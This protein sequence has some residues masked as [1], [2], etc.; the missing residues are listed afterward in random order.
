MTFKDYI[1]IGIGGA[2]GSIARAALAYYL[3]NQTGLFP[4]GT[5]LANCTGCFLIGL[6]TSLTINYTGIYSYGGREILLFLITGFCGGFTTFSTFSLEA[7]RLWQ[8]AHIVEAFWYTLA[9]LLSGFAST[10]AGLATG[11]SINK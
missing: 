3:N 8:Q 6:F 9:S 11:G 1:L 4:G 7:L 5:F 10:A 2:L